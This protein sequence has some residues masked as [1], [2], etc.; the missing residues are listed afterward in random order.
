MMQSAPEANSIPPTRILVVEDESII[1]MDIKDCLE[2]LGYV[3]TAIATSGSEAIAHAQAGQADL[4]LMDVRLRGD[5]DGIEA[6][7]QIWERFRIPVI[8]ATGYSDQSTLE[9][10]KVTIPFGYILKP[11]EERELYVA[12]ETALQR[13][14]FEQELHAREQWLSTILT[15]IG[16]GV[17]VVDNQRRIQF[18]NR[19]ATELTGWQPMEVVN[20][21]LHEVFQLV[22]EQT[23]KPL[24]SPVD[25]ALATGETSYLVDRSLLITKTGEARPV[26][27]SA[28]P[29]RNAQG[30]I[31]G[32]V[33]VFRDITQQRLAAQSAAAIARAG[34]LELEKHE[35]QR[36]SQLKDDFLNTISHELRTPLANIKMAAHML[37]IV[38]DQLGVL[39]GDRNTRSESLTRYMQILNDQCN[40]ELSL[41]ND[42]LDLQKINANAYPF[43]PSTIQLQNW[44]PHM[45][46]SFQG[47][48]QERQQRLQIIVPTNLPLLT[49]D[50][51]SLTRIL[52]ELLNN[53]CKYTPSGETITITAQVR[54]HPP[55]T[56]LA[57]PETI[58]P[59]MPAPET[60]APETTAPKNTAPQNTAPDAAAAATDSPPDNSAAIV[61]SP[62][63]PADVPHCWITV[64]N[65]GVEIPADALP[66][67]FEQFYRIPA[68]DR[69][70]Q[71]GSGLGLAL[72]SRL[73]AHLGGRIQVE[74]G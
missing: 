12:I 17:I 28:A 27:D 72:V 65:S 57:I 43:D 20:R 54:S 32:V 30:K 25:I 68:A 3:V 44:L 13:Y 10:A 60:I 38:L 53:A 26:A 23:L 24:D 52:S 45:S 9:R 6:A 73:A 4:V 50:R 67:I 29:F 18:F 5:T 1:A 36:L 74:S 31:L 62:N 40:Q 49:S 47:R 71:G 56:P 2:N 15:D 33:L 42:L 41:V 22:D 64:S 69:W 61:P 58:S 39:D 19:I 63:A 11:I 34:Q 66:H 8:Y 21:S 55:I 37:G 14:R 59:E 35:L 46:E 51:P 48:T 16:D 70:N 7:E